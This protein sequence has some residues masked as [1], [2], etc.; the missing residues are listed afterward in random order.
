MV[1]FHII[2]PH[3]TSVNDKPKDSMKYFVKRRCKKKMV[4][5]KRRVCY[6]NKLQMHILVLGN[7]HLVRVGGQAMYE[8]KIGEK[9]QK[10]DPDAE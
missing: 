9:H 8:G 3:F 10:A 5:E 7:V 6:D 2:H 1:T 4:E